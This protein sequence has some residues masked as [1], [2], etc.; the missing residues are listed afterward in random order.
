MH[1]RKMP[2][3]ASYNVYCFPYA[4]CQ[5][6]PTIK[7]AYVSNQRTIQRAVCYFVA[8]LAIWKKIRLTIESSH[9]QKT[10]T[11]MHLA[12]IQF[13]DIFKNYETNCCQGCFKKIQMRCNILRS[14]HHATNNKTSSRPIFYWPV[15]YHIRSV[16]ER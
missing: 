11:N 1:K 4:Y 8:S 15:L 5:I 2:A 9:A 12:Q 7:S 6:P 3:G 13:T 14:N 10:W 16:N